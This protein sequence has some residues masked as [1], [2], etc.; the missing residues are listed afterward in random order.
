MP[1][2]CIYFKGNAIFFMFSFFNPRKEKL[3]IISIEFSRKRFSSWSFPI[4]LIAY[5]SLSNFLNTALWEKKKLLL[6]NNFCRLSAVNNIGKGKNVSNLICYCEE[7]NNLDIRKSITHF[8]CVR[9]RDRKC[10]RMSNFFMNFFNKNYRKKWIPT[11]W[12][13]KHRQATKNQ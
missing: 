13:P 8:F 9:V 11:P 12:C 6:P 3:L 10:A 1:V 7:G 2:H 4:F 5:F